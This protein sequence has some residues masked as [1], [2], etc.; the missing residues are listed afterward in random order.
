MFYRVLVEPYLMLYRV[1]LES[2]RSLL[3]SALLSPDLS[4]FLLS[5][6]QFGSEYAEI[7]SVYRDN[8]CMAT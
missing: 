8:L 1:L 3:S 7:C 2:D 5:I 6:T 4:V